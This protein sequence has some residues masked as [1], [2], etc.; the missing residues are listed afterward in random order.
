MRAFH[1]ERCGRRCRTVLS[2]PYNSVVRGDLRRI[3]NLAKT[4]GGLRRCLGTRIDR[5]LMTSARRFAKVR[6]GTRHSGVCS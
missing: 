1:T 3:T 4:N 2:C 5:K 6:L